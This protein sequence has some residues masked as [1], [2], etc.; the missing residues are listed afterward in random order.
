MEEGSVE[1]EGK[2]GNRDDE[3]TGVGSTSL[4]AVQSEGQGDTGGR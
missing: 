1:G 2:Q 4:R 3:M